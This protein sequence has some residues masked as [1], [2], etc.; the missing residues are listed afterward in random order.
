MTVFTEE[1]ARAIIDAYAKRTG[2]TV[3]VA[4]VLDPEAPTITDEMEETITG[5]IAA[6]Y[7]MLLND[8]PPLGYIATLMVMDTAVAAQAEPGSV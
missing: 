2:Q 6:G 5:L 7:A 4:S 3:R 1:R 8:M